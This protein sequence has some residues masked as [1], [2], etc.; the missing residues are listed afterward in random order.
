MISILP[1]DVSYNLFCYCFDCPLYNS[2]ASP[3]DYS[4]FN[5]VLNYLTINKS[6]VRP[7]SLANSRKLMDSVKCLRI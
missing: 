5:P 7:L 4:D 1:L 2:C 3:W 6:S